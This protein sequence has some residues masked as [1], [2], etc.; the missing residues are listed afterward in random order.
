[1]VLVLAGAG[2]GIAFALLTGSSAGLPLV[3]PPVKAAA[4]AAFLRSSFGTLSLDYTQIDDRF[5]PSGGGPTAIFQLLESVDDRLYTINNSTRRNTCLT[6]TPVH[7]S[8]SVFTQTVDFYFQCYSMWSDNSGF[9]MFGVNGNTTYLYTYGG[10][11]ST[12]FTIQSLGNDYSKVTGWLAVGAES[13]GTCNGSYGAIQIF[14]NNDPAQQQFEVS[15]AG[16][17]MGFC[18]AN[19]VANKTTLY[20]IGSA[21]MGSTCVATDTLCANATD[22][23]VAESDCTILQND[24]ALPAMGRMAN[25]DKGWGASDYPGGTADQIIM[26][27][28]SSDSAHFGPTSVLAGTTQFEF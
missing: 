13:G 24:R 26:S 27:C 17:G 2:V 4:P 20:A 8:M 16:S 12:A 9:I 10:A 5:F 3:T 6:A 23:S 14:A 19:V 1:V 15:C 28:D 18:G 25:A 21:D 7:Y 11:G 22:L